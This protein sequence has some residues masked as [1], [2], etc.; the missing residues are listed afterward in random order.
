MFVCARVGRGIVSRG[1]SLAVVVSAVAL[2]ATV[3]IFL[4]VSLWLC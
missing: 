3:G 2:G 1:L 4:A